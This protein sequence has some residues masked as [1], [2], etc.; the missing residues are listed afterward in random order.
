VPAPPDKLGLL[1]RGVDRLSTALGLSASEAC[2][3][4]ARALF[5]WIAKPGEPPKAVVL[6]AIARHAGD[7]RLPLFDSPEPDPEADSRAEALAIEIADL[8]AVQTW[9]YED[10][11]WLGELF[12]G[13]LGTRSRKK[14]GAFY[15]PRAIVT[16]LLDE[17]LPPADRP[18]SKD[19]RL[20]DPSCGA[21][22]FLAAALPALFERVWT[23]ESGPEGRALRLKRVMER[24]L[25]GIDLDPWAVR[26]AQV[27]LDFL[28]R[29]LVPEL[30]QPFRARLLGQDALQSHH[31][32]LEAGFDVIVGNP[33]YGAELSSDDK[34]FF[35]RHYRLGNG[36][37]ETTALFIERSAALLRPGGRLALVV[38]HGVT[39]TGAYA[40][41]RRLLTHELRLRALIDLG[42]AFP[43]VNLETMAF[44]AERPNEGG[45]GTVL[46]WG[47]SPESRVSLAT[48]R[49]GPL[50]TLG[51]QSHDFY[52]HRP[53]LPIY[54]NAESR[55]VERIESAGVP[56]QDIAAIRR[57]A[58]VSANQEAI[59]LRPGLTVVR[60]RDIRRYGDEGGWLSLHAEY[61]LR[62]RYKKD[63]LADPAIAFQNIASSVVATRLPAGCL[64]LDTVNLLD[65]SE[66]WHPD[67]VLALLNSRLLEAYFRLAIANRGQLTLHL[68]TPT[69]GSLPIMEAD[70]TEQGA[71]ADLVDRVFA[72]LVGTSTWDLSERLEAQVWKSPEALQAAFHEWGQ[73]ATRRRKDAQAILDRLDERIGELYGL[74]ADELVVAHEAAPRTVKRPPKELQKACELVMVR[75]LIRLL[76]R[77]DREIDLS[78]LLRRWSRPDAETLLM[79]WG[80]DRIRDL[81]EVLARY[82]VQIHGRRA[83]L[84]QP[85]FASLAL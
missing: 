54:V 13:R 27:R 51:H 67:Y 65:L 73:D 6:R 78:E 58:G 61:P 8:F 31:P 2:H 9:G 84:W 38:P 11:E 21:G 47:Q 35:Q 18:L 34:A 79:T 85:G 15:T 60:G 26:L 17:V 64:P 62:D 77:A 81:P 43:G 30:A 74:S 20:L 53:T 56:L 10:G 41:C 52:L 23:P 55:W 42:S 45:P 40:D 3:T 4:I 37:Q 63:V 33:P 83:G 57:G 7:H 76:E 59:A 28:Q 29:Q 66:G 75:G 71:I 22:N 49:D 16:H 46:P 19:F 70:P 68:D 24:H 12:E 39:R 44:V 1:D 50:V 72:C 25:F 82:G 32:I 48:F 80:G 36:R 5:H 69:I 14:H